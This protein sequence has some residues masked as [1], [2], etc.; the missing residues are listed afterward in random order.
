VPL[1]CEEIFKRIDQTKGSATQFEVIQL[2]YVE[3]LRN[4]KICF[5]HFKVTFSMLEIYSE[6]VRDLLAPQTD[7][8]QGLLI[9]EDPKI[10]FYRKNLKLI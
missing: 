9:R 4:L 6:A 8:R 2:F 10:G 5:N 3:L 7:K 1:I